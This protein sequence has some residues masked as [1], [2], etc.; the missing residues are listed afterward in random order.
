MKTLVLF[1][2]ADGSY[3]SISLDKLADFPRKGHSYLL[4]KQV[5]EVT[6][7]IEPVGS[8]SGNAQMLHL[9]NLDLNDAASIARAVSSMIN[10]DND[11]KLI[12]ITDEPDRVILVRVKTTRAKSKV[13]LADLDLVIDVQALFSQAQERV[14]EDA[15]SVA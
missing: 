13:R 9:L 1:R 12:L 4:N 6:E 2:V 7:V 8:E 11:S 15:D 3:M 5:Y 10:L 14:D